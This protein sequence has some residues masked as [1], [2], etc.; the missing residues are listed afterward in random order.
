MYDLHVKYRGREINPSSVN[1]SR[2]NIT[3]YHFYQKPGGLNV[4]GSVKFMFPNKHDVYLHDTQEK[5]YFNRTN[6]AESHGCVRVQNPRRLAEVLLRK[7]RGWSAGKTGSH[8]AG[9]YNHRVNL[10][11]KVPVHITY[12]TAWVDEKGSLR[13]YGDLYGHD[14]RMASAMRL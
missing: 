12:F 1:W 10:N 6:R 4:L 9:G 13:T 2:A 11:N 3:Q 5:F 8:F 7:D 14:G